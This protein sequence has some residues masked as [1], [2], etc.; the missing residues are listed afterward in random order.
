MAAVLEVPPDCLPAGASPLHLAA[1]NEDI[2][3]LTLLLAD[4]VY[5]IDLADRHGR[6]PLVVALQN[7]RFSAAKVLIEYGA[8]LDV[9]YGKEAVCVR[10]A[11]CLP[12][13]LPLLEMLVEHSV[14]VNPSSS[15]SGAFAGLMHSVAY[16][17]RVEFLKVLLEQYA[18]DVDTKDSL[19]CTP[20]HYSVQRS[21]LDCVK[22]LLARG[23]K[24][25]ATCTNGLKLTCIHVACQ[26]G[27][28]EILQA[29]MDACQSIGDLLNAQDCIGR[30]PLHIALYCS[31][32]VA[33]TYLVSEYSS[34]IDTSLADA[35]GHTLQSLSFTVRFAP[36]SPPQ[37]TA[38][39]PC[40]S[41]EEATWL[42]HDS[43][44]GG[45][46]NG[47]NFALD[48]GAVI[49]CYDLMQQTP[50]LAAA[51]QGSLAVC[52]TLVQRGA[53]VNLSD[54]AG[55]TPVH[56]AAQYG[57]SQVFS[58]L[59]SCMDVDLHL[60]YALYDRPLSTDIL[61]LLLA[62]LESGVADRPG[63]GAKWL[64]LA[65]ACATEETFKRFAGYI[66]QDGLVDCL[67]TEQTSDAL[68]VLFKPV[69]LPGPFLS[70]FPSRSVCEKRKNFPSFRRMRSYPPG[71]I[72]QSTKPSKKTAFKE[73]R[74]HLQSPT[75][76]FKTIPAAKKTR[77]PFRTTRAKRNKAFTLP[78]FHFHFS[79]RKLYSP[80]H[81]VV[82]HTN[83]EVFNLILS[84]AG[85]DT[86]LK[87]RLLSLKD[88]CG[89][90]VLNRVAE[91]WMSF[92]SSVQRHAL[93]GF[94]FEQLERQFPLPASLP[95]L[96]A[97]LLHIFAGEQWSSPQGSTCTVYSY[98]SPFSLAVLR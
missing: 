27:N 5:D 20:L 56:Y 98:F 26:T 63:N 50:L 9:R 60:F 69:H 30:T 8:S 2:K 89:V 15:T 44:A 7:G 57:H 22:V 67:L 75:L 18:L 6:S 17:G 40:M 84:Q 53:K 96:V 13:F 34:V 4:S 74:K 59:L 73:T 52:E 68:K 24:P 46:Y 62:A 23:A 19:D 54:V 12:V 91:K 79:S 32:L 49:D 61:Q 85:E 16:E 78:P 3:T 97:V 29:L 36:S 80:L 28:L 86:F 72:F 87:E 33:F 1:N 82:R 65:A 58:F 39:I 21:L 76:T 88:K 47:V 10:E 93:T 83:V 77:P 41:R 81:D 14:H 31:R 92:S 94:V 55:R 66:C 95:L 43:V 42:L 35:Y 90:M 51:K 64:S 48:H 45:H 70:A 11:L 71:S 38:L 37:S 25:G